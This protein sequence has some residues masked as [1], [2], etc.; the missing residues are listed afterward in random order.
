MKQLTDLTEMS[1]NEVVKNA[2]AIMKWFVR[3]KIHRRD[4]LPIVGL[5]IIGA[6]KDRSEADRFMSTLADELDW[7][8]GEATQ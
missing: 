3:H 6:L 5:V 1:R 7:K 4:G 8:F 2:T